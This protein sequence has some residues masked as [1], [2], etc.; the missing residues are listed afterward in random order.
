MAENVDPRKPHPTLPHLG[1]DAGRWPPTPTH[2]TRKQERG[3]HGPQ[4][5]GPPSEAMSGWPRA[6]P[7]PFP[8]R[9][10]P[11]SLHLW[12]N[13]C[14]TLVLSSSWGRRRAGQP[15]EPPPRGSSDDGAYISWA[16]PPPPAHQEPPLAAV[17]LVPKPRKPKAGFGHTFPSP[18]PVAAPHIRGTLESEDP[19]HTTLGMVP[20]LSRSHLPVRPASRPCPSPLPRATRWLGTPVAAACERP[21]SLHTP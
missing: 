13:W 10:S 18:L 6:L 9:S 7:S 16:V 14:Y 15:W 20:L 21:P 3:G 5:R 11:H 4:L 17:Q 2:R 8:P 19:T 1:G 12:G